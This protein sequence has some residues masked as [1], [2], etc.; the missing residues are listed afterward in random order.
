MSLIFLNMLVF[1]LPSE[2][3]QLHMEGAGNHESQCKEVGKSTLYEEGGWDL[4]KHQLGW[5]KLPWDCRV[6]LHTLFL[7]LFL[8]RKEIA[9]YPILNE[10]KDTSPRNIQLLTSSS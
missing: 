3:K 5:L 1:C 6:L 2:L 10:S 8:H 7:K 4:G 9:F